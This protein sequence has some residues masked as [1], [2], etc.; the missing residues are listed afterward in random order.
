MFPFTS[1]NANK[2]D[3]REVKGSS[4]MSLVS[5]FKLSEDS[6]VLRVGIGAK[7]LV[8]V[9]VLLLPERVPDGAIIPPSVGVG[10]FIQ[11]EHRLNASPTSC[12]EVLQWG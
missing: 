11:M 2:A 4:A 7:R 9:V 1:A 8:R 5:S 12:L 3:A 6:L 10:G